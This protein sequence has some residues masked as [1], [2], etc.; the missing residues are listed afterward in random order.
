MITHWID[1]QAAQALLFDVDGTL[2]ETE[3]EGHLPAFNEAFE[4]LGIPWDWWA[5]QYA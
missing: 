2:A 5:D 3:L 4:R 1:P